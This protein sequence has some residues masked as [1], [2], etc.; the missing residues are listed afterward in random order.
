VLVPFFSRG[1][2]AGAAVWALGAAVLP[3]ARRGR[4]LA[5]DVVAVVVWSLALMAG[6][7]AASASG[8]LSPRP[9]AVMAG[10]IGAIL[11]ALAPWL[12]VAQLGG[13]RS[14]S[15]GAGLA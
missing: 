10:A 11:L 6:T 2:I 8:G 1:L 9:S 4:R 15:A 7:L 5:S 14:A 12:G 3:F 13:R